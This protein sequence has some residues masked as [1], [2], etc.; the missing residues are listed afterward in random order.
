M[1]DANKYGFLI[2]RDVAKVASLFPRKRTHTTVEMGL[3]E[4]ATDERIVELAWERQLIIVTG[5]GDEF[6]AKILKFQSKTQK[7][8]CH[9]LSGLIVLSSGFELQKRLLIVASDRLRFGGTRIT[10]A[11]VW[12]KNYCVKLRRNSNPEVTRFPQCL[13]CRKLQEK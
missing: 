7:L 1:A 10:W 9:D 3:P 11:D 2:D 8:V 5:N 4:D 6:V 13:Y 12:N